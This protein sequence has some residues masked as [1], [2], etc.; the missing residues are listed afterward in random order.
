[1]HEWPPGLPL[2]PVIAVGRFIAI[3]RALGAEGISAMF[4]KFLVDAARQIQ[5]KDPELA[6]M[7]ESVSSKWMRESF[8]VNSVKAGM[9][10]HEVAYRIGDRAN[11]HPFRN[12]TDLGR[13]DLERAV[14]MHI[15][16]PAAE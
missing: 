11:Q 4:K 1:V 3:D 12:E 2:V 6:T 5:Q 15:G 16:L 10:V 13:R 7:L 8:A 9:P 14:F